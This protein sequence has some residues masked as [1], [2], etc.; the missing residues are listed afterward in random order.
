MA[1]S[2][3]SIITIDDHQLSIWDIPPE[4]IV[5]IF[6]WLD[7]RL[8]LLRCVHSH[9]KSIVDSFFDSQTETSASV[10]LEDPCLFQYAQSMNKNRSAFD[11][12][13]INNASIIQSLHKNPS[14]PHLMQ[15]LFRDD[16]ILPNDHIVCPILSKVAIHFAIVGRVDLL[17]RW[18][19][20]SG[21]I[22]AKDGY[23]YDNFVNDLIRAILLESPESSL[24]WLIKNFPIFFPDCT[25]LDLMEGYLNSNLLI[26]NYDIVYKFNH[27]SYFRSVCKFPNFFYNLFT[28]G[29]FSPPL[30]FHQIELFFALVKQPNPFCLGIDH[31]NSI[32]KHEIIYQQ[33]SKIATS[34]FCVPGPSRRFYPSN[35]LYRSMTE[36]DTKS[37]REELLKFVNGFSI[38]S[39]DYFF[40]QYLTFLL[41]LLLIGWEEIFDFVMDL[42]PQSPTI[43]TRVITKSWSYI[44][45]N[46]NNRP[47]F[48]SFLAKLLDQLLLELPDTQK[49]GN[50]VYYLFHFILTC[51][52]LVV[53]DQFFISFSKRNHLSNLAF[54]SRYHWLYILSDEAIFYLFVKNYESLGHH[55]W[56]FIFTQTSLIK[57][58]IEFFETS[59][60]RF[61]SDDVI[62]V[63]V[64]QI[65]HLQSH[66]SKY[67]ESSATFARMMYQSFHDL[68]LCSCCPKYKQKDVASLIE[69]FHF[70]HQHPSNCDINDVQIVSKI[71]PRKFQYTYFDESFTPKAIFFDIDVNLFQK[72]SPDL[73]DNVIQSIK[74]L[75]TEPCKQS[76]IN[77]KTNNLFAAIAM[78]IKKK[79]PASELAKYVKGLQKI[80]QLGLIPSNVTQVDTILT[81]L[82]KL[83]RLDLLDQFVVKSFTESVR[84]ETPQIYFFNL[85]IKLCKSKDQYL[86]FI[87]HP[88][89]KNFPQPKS[90]FV[91]K[92]FV[93]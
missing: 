22:P 51:N 32:I 20:T 75:S 50:A 41:H 24:D 8:G 80:H 34:F 57:K 33:Q 36:R 17:T 76:E 63:A 21:L 82:S 26:F 67:E 43:L 5:E 46:S 31:S 29:K 25:T 64:K 74:N 10:L 40:D 9:W 54:L 88:F 78:S 79:K 93:Q 59:K 71:D 12:I 45:I 83:N 35:T 11:K 70:L 89:F 1:S 85:L 72:I 2:V 14:N 73:I 16:S 77:E 91:N 37:F 28:S 69:F 38:K 53:I 3:Q 30:S 4:L 19:N 58:S 6:G 65:I 48:G 61:Q 86:Q 87:S 90:I 84:P 66:G 81:T 15:L 13:K 18:L 56:N 68:M 62:V 42:F 23:I 52:D 49:I 55:F 60:I 47:S 92:T 7:D 27:E 44:S 39:M